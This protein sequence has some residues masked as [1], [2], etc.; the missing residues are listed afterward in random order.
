MEKAG[1]QRCC[2]DNH[3]HGD[4]C[5]NFN[6]NCSITSGLLRRDICLFFSGRCVLGC[7]LL[8]LSQFGEDVAEVR[9]RAICNCERQVV[10]CSKK[11]HDH[12]DDIGGRNIG[13]ANSYPQ[14]GVLVSQKS[15]RHVRSLSA[16]P[17]SHLKAHLHVME[18]IVSAGS[19]HHL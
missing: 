13:R 10:R 17:Q 1:H 16:V 18:S 19:N 6:K 4:Q 3:F 11:R 7:F 14:N 8:L 15:N 9:W 12:P 2:A 5:K